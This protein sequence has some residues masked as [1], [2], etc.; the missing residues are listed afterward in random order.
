LLFE[1]LHNFNIHLWKVY[2]R[3]ALKWFSYILS[4]YIKLNFLSSVRERTIPTERSPLVGEASAKFADR[5]CHVVSVTDP[6]SQFWTGPIY[7]YTHTHT[8]LSLN[9]LISPLIYIY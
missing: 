4:I 5:G 3:R 2:H 7:I 9:S 8:H 1:V 6:Y